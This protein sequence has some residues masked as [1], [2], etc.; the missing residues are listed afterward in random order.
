MSSVPQFISEVVE[1]VKCPICSIEEFVVIE[2]S[3]YPDEIATGDLLTLYHSSSD[4]MLIDQL[5]SCSGCSLVYLNP[6]VRSDIILKSYTEAVDATF[7]S[8]NQQRIKTFKKSL[9]K[10]CRRYGIN[11]GPEKRV[12]DLGCAGGAF[13]KAAADL[14]FSVV[15]IEPSRWLC[16]YGQKEYGLDLRPGTLETYSFPERYF[17][18]VTLWDVIEHL[19]DPLPILC[20]IQPIL[21][22]DGLLVINFPDY[23]SI[24]RILFGRRWPFF[25]SVHLSYFT[26]ITLEKV[27]EKAGFKVINCSPYWQTLEMGYI[28]QRAAA[29]FPVFR[30][31]GQLLAL[32]RLSKIGL[33]YNMGQSLVVAKKVH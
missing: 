18:L 6:R 23:S 3:S 25:L 17:D 29:Y 13:P 14:G 8:Q 15:G 32:M 1:E 9:R 12:L 30:F 24:A 10:L 2:P 16:E 20:R 26:P 28:C 5:V 19:V 33:A 7:I 22:E 4:K 31:L 21:A 11:P 27:L